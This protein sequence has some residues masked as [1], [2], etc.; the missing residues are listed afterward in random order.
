MFIKIDDNVVIQTDDIREAWAT[1]IGTGHTR[2]N[3]T[4]RDGSNSAY[5]TDH[6]RK[7]LD[8]IFKS[9]EDEL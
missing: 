8:Q 2:I 3:I 4:F 1:G 6:P 7:Y 9:L 5:N